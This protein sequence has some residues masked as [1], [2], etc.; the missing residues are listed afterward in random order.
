MLTIPTVH[1]KDGMVQSWLVHH[2]VHSSCDLP[3][4]PGRTAHTRVHEQPHQVRRRRLGS[5]CARR[6]LPYIH[7]PGSDEQKSDRQHLRA[8]RPWLVLSI[9]VPCTMLATMYG[10]RPLRVDALC[11]APVRFRG[12]TRSRS[13]EL[14]M[15]AVLEQ[16]SAV[17]ANN[18]RSVQWLQ[19]TASSR[20]AVHLCM[21]MEQK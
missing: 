4:S 2:G 17:R 13:S 20:S 16:S 10:G 3:K 11:S 12:L 5:Q 9:L 15:L 1:H 6:P 19:C 7:H 18:K 14:P 21:V 8:V